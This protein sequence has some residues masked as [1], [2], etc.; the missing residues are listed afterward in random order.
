MKKFLTETILFISILLAIFTLG[1]LLPATP[2]AS[3]SL[4]FSKIAKDSL[5][6]NVPSPRIIFVGGSNLSFGLNSQMIKDSLGLNPI[7]TSVIASIGLIYMMENTLQYLKKGDHVVISSEYDMFFGTHAYGGENLLRT[8][9]DVSPVTAM[10]LRKEQW[11]NIFIYLPKFSFSK[12]IPLDYFP[13]EY[14]NMI[15]AYKKENLLYGLKSYNEYG[16]VITHWNLHNEKVQSFG[17][18][19]EEFNYSIVKEIASFNIKVKEKGAFLY[20]T[21]PGFQARSFENSKEQ[22]LKVEEELRK[23]DFKLLGNPS[24]YIF[25]DSLLFNTPYHLT[26]EG[27]DIRTNYLIEDIKRENK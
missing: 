1:I 8:V 18:I 2:R 10:K 17:T 15:P 3:K 4:L 27:A 14:L 20:I 6:E 26:K 19:T 5:L 13:T 9:I 21:F 7:N 22:I 12:Y 25:S 11:Q 16:D 24:R 23:S